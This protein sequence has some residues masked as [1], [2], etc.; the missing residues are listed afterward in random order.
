MFYVSKSVT[1]YVII[2]YD[3][4]NSAGMSFVRGT[5][6]VETYEL[7]THMSWQTRRGFASVF[8]PSS[9]NTWSLLVGRHS[10]MSSIKARL[11][12]ANAVYAY[13]HP[14]I[15]M[16]PSQSQMQVTSVRQH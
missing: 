6:A 5:C 9:V 1:K 16:L 12:P 14:A 15:N 7:L 8:R 11:S 4:G 13:R 10:A 3:D 2:I